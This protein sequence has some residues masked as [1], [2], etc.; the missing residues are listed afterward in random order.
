MPESLVRV[1][2]QIV[3]SGLLVGSHGRVSTGRRRI[4]PTCMEADRDKVRLGRCGDQRPPLKVTGIDGDRILG[5]FAR[6]L[7]CSFGNR[8]R[9]HHRDLVSHVA[10][11]VSSG[12]RGRRRRLGEEDGCLRR[13]LLL[14]QLADKEADAGESQSESDHEQTSVPDQREDVRL[15]GTCR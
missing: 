11:F 3:A 8:Q 15:D 13:V 10:R 4:R 14:P 5:I 6:D 7:A 1:V 2:S 12:I 9:L